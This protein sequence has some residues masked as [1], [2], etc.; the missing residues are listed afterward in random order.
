MSQTPED[1]VTIP[2]SKLVLLAQEGDEKAFTMLFN[3]YR[4]AL[5][6]YLLGL[7]R[8]T[9]DRDDLAQEAFF[10]AWK[11]LP[12]L[13]DPSLFKPWLYT[14][15]TNLVRDKKRRKPFEKVPLEKGDTCEAPIRFEDA[16]AERDLVKQALEKVRWKRRICLLLEIEGRLTLDEIAQVMG[17]GKRSVATY[18]SDARQE[19]RQAYY[20]LEQRQHTLRERRLV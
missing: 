17:I 14:I 2:H 8:N 18:I 1:P 5:G 15:A 9:E 16:V 12:R 6:R 19:F 11:E 10:K 3:Y 13:R 7:L 20:E 4:P